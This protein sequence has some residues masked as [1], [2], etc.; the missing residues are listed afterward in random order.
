MNQA[1]LALDYID[2]VIW[3]LL[4]A[5][6]VW[7]LATKFRAEFAA[8]IGRVKSV[9][10]PLGTGVQMTEQKT[11]D[12][13]E[14]PAVVAF[15]A[16]ILERKESEIAGHILATGELT[17]QLAMYQ[18]LHSFERIYR[19]IFGSQ[20]RLLYYLAS[21]GA[22]GAGLSDVVPYHQDNL[23]LMR[24]VIPAYDYQLAAYLGFL[25]GSELI[26]M[27]EG[28]Y[29]ITEPGRGFLQWMAAESVQP[30]KPG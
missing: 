19:L 29:H 2:V 3:P 16:G 22:T 14:E 10:G 9:S 18:V 27:Q 7:L 12:V 8:L 21:A 5:A 17:R 11:E 4:V 1:R 25:Q 20:I 15:L 23:R 13:K 28:R 26:R 30:W 24:A 6:V